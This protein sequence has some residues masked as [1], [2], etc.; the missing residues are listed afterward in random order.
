MKYEEKELSIITEAKRL[1]SYIFNTTQNSQQKFR[2]SLTGRMQG[3][4]LDIVDGLYDANDVFVEN[5]LVKDLEK[6]IRYEEE[7]DK[8]SDKLLTLR[9]ARAKEMNTRVELRLGNQYKVRTLIKK[10]EH[11]VTLASEMNCIRMNQREV[12]AE[13]I[14]NIKKL[15]DAWIKS[16]KKRYGYE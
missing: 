14:K 6:S 5:K 4:S 11:L 16:D 13:H 10:L 8:N 3:I 1:S 12:M 2:F 15:L 7:R 9:L